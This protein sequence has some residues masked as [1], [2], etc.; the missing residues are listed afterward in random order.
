MQRLAAVAIDAGLVVDNALLLESDSNDAWRIDDAVVRVCWRGDPTRLRREALVLQS[1]P[2]TVPHPELLGVGTSSGLTWTLTRWVSGEL[3]SGA[4]RTMR[5]SERDRL[6]ED[7]ANAFHS[8][9][10]WSPPPE[11]AAAI[12]QRS[13]ARTFDEVVGQDVNPLPVDRALRLVEPAKASPHVD[14]AMV[15]RLAERMMELRTIDPLSEPGHRVVHSDA[16]LGTVLTTGGRLSCLL[17]F[18][19]VRVGPRDLELQT[20]L[21]TDEA[22]H[23]GLAIN[24]LGRRYSELVS[25]ARLVERLW[26]YDLAFVLRHLVVWPA[27]RSASDLPPFHPIRRLPLIVESPAYIERLLRSA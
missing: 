20:F 2:E 13:P 21:R 24:S 25:H 9:H 18:E 10:E 22:G 8:L 23:P 6:L 27:R 1:L 5:P 3:A 17:D 16:H 26:L 19:W 11:V 12:E 15:D 7:L 14:A 4:W